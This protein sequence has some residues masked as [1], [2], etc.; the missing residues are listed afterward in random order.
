[1]TGRA[2]RDGLPSECVLLYSSADAVRL[3]RLIDE[4][5]DE[6]EQTVS[7]KHLSKL[8]E[9]CE[10]AGCRRVQLLQYFGET[11]RAGSGE[12]LEACGA[13]DNCLTPREQI[14]GTLAGQKLLSCVLRIQ[15]KSGFGVGLHHVVDVLCGSE[16][17]KV[18]RW[19]H[20]TLSTYGIGKEHSRSEWAHFARELMRLGLLHQNTAPINL[21][22]V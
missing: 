16:T 21:L 5:T 14:D 22:E 11:Y 1:E 8:I 7:R 15:Q 13:C 17:E 10:S 19:G 2:G 12:A 20:Q 9:F 6:Q 4:I 3:H 18:Q